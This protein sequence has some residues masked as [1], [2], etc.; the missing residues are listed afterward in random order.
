MFGI[1]LAGRV[2]QSS[3]RKIFEEVLSY[4]VDVGLMILWPISYSKYRPKELWLMSYLYITISKNLADVFF[5]HRP[6]G[7]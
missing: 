6:N 2:V 1:L 5:K 3:Q 7:W 4:H